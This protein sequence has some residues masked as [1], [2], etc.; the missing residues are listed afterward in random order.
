MRHYVAATRRGRARRPACYHARHPHPPC[1]DLTSVSD[2]QL[3]TLAWRHYEEA[4]GA[5]LRDPQIE[6]GVLAAAADFP[7][8]VALRA[9]AFCARVGL[10]PLLQRAH[11]RS[12]QAAVL[13]V[14]AGAV[15]GVG[16]AGLIPDGTPARANLMDM[17]AALLVPNLLALLL[18]LLLQLGGSLRG[19]GPAGIWFGSVLQRLVERVSG[20]PG[21]GAPADVTRAVQR[22]LVDYYATTPAGRLHLASLSHLFWLALASGAMLG[23]WWLLALRQID[24]YWGS[25]LL[26]PHTITQAFDW[27]ARPV[28]WLG[29][30]VPG[31]ADVAASRIDAS[32]QDAAL[33]AR[34]GWFLLSAL[35]VF[36]VLPRLVAFAGCQALAAW[37]AR[38]PVIDAA[39]P[40]YWRLR[41]FLLPT[42]T[43]TR[44]LD[45]DDGASPRPAVPAPADTSEALPHAAAWLA[46]ERA[47][48]VPATATDLGVVVDRP[49]Q[50]RVLA[51]LAADAP[52]PALVVQAPLA[53]TP[54]RGLA[55]FVAALVA[56]AGR[57]VHLHIAGAAAAALSPV[58][59]A[60]R[61]EDWRAL[62]Q[63][64]GVPP[65]CVSVAA[66]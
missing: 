33:R 38:R 26:G 25:T 20:D 8:R 56:A 13:A 17:L 5:P 63:A 34:W 23:C 65:A 3:Q 21:R 2:L 16:T 19:R 27:L 11:R 62:A 64:A 60:A 50:Q 53:A 22:G 7:H 24:F 47:L 31:A 6:A 43:A 37:A 10:D 41:S 46:L 32:A 4:R 44:V 66:S 36:G 14:F 52:W 28:G 45:P 48:P 57:P 54:D 49:A 61:V 55:Q 29:L 30:P 39:Q 58:D 59:L 42:P 9:R 15:L 51:A 12:R 40:G 35:G 1:I 18:W